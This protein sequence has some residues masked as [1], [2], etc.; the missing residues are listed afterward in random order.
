MPRKV[1]TY[2]PSDSSSQAPTPKHLTKQ[3]FGR[4]VYQHMLGKGWTQSELSR[5]ADIPRDSISVYV[6]GRS[7]PTPQNLEKLAKAFGVTADDLLPNHTETAIVDEENPAFEM[8]VSTAAPGMA[9]LRVNRMVSMSTAVKIAAIL[10]NDDVSDRGGSRGP[11]AVQ[12]V[13]NKAASA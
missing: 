4:R 9:W 11:A 13:E 5:K 12:S 8:K 10:E 2:V 3:E 7:M 6:R 1:H